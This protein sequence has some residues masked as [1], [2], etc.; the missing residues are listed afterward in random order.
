[1]GRVL[2]SPPTVVSTPLLTLSSLKPTPLANLPPL[3]CMC[4][5][6]GE[7]AGCL[8]ETEINAQIL[9]PSKRASGQSLKTSAT[10]DPLLDQELNSLRRSILCQKNAGNERQEKLF[11]KLLDNLGFDRSTAESVSPIVLPQGVMSSPGGLI[12]PAELLLSRFS[13]IATGRTRVG[14]YSALER[15]RKIRKYKEK[16]KKWRGQHP[17]SRKF[18]GRRRVAFVK[19]RLNGRFAK[20]S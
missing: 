2:T 1:M 3:D 13:S 9:F 17:I 6:K 19:N 10:A 15:Q 11:F 12:L 5:S 18:D 16:L 8:S 14:L 20:L 7:S 4:M